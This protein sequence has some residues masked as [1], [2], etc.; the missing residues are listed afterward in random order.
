MI[1]QTQTLE[2]T[3]VLRLSELLGEVLESFTALIQQK[4]LIVEMDISDHLQFSGDPFLMKQ[5][6]LNIIHNA[7]DFMPENGTLNITAKARETEIVL[8]I[9]NEGS[10]I[11][12]YA[13]T[14]LYERFYS[15]PRPDSGEKSTGLGLNFVK[16]VIALHQGEM[17]VE[18][19]TS[20]SANEASS[21]ETSSQIQGVNV[22]IILPRFR[23]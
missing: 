8:N 10:F 4:S 23:H 2:S 13:L 19:R 16:E 6:L 5:A 11:P 9:F 3:Q 7:I 1:E 20:S 21:S 12:E 18:N 14:R 22:E 17:S 15:L